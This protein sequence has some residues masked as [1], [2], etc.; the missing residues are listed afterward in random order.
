VSSS[1]SV[2][3]NT[4]WHNHQAAGR[5]VPTLLSTIPASSVTDNTGCT[6]ESNHVNITVLTPP[7]VSI[8]R[9]GDTLT[10]YGASH[11]QWYLN[12]NPIPGATH[13]TCIANAYG[14]Y[15]VE[16]TDANGCSSVSQPV[17]I[18]GDENIN[19][20]DNISIYPNPLANGNWQLQVDNRLIGA[21]IEIYDDNGRI[22]YTAEIKNL[23]TEISPQFSS[24]VY[25]L[26][27][28]SGTSVLS[29]KLVK[30]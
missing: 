3:A 1:V 17:R 28:I 16:V 6:A 21:Q 14:N 18:T 20:D 13:N 4:G 2:A 26:H 15:T 19:E 23:R 11:V 8:S 7:Q 25:F 29:R 12:N 22:V 30:L 5:P 24:G 27:I 10:A 9:N